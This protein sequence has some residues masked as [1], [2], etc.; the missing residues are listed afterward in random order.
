MEGPLA[1]IQISQEEAWDVCFAQPRTPAQE[2]L[3]VISVRLW[4][5]KVLFTLLLLFW[6]RFFTV[7]IQVVL[8]QLLLQ[9]LFQTQLLLRQSIQV[10]VLLIFPLSISDA[11]SA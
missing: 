8:L 3:G 1:P 4:F 9:S 11:V 7:P 2:N 5:F 6:L 10:T